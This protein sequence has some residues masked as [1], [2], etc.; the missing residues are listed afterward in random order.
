MDNQLLT[1]K[2]KDSAFLDYLPKIA[3]GAGIIFAG[4]IIGNGLLYLFN[5]IVAR[6]LGSAAYGLFSIGRIIINIAFMLALFGLQ[7]GILRYVSIY[8]GLRDNER[9]KGAIISALKVVIPLSLVVSALLFG[10]AETISTQIF[11]KKELTIVIKLFSISIPFISLSTIFISVTKGF[12]KMQ[13]TVYARHIFEPIIKMLLALTL[14]LI[15]WKLM[16]AV[17]AFVIANIFSLFLCFYYLKNLFPIFNSQIKPI[18]ETKKL[19]RF[20]FPLL[21]V[22]LLS[23]LMLRIDI[24]MLG[25]F[26]TAE[27][28]GIYSAAMQTS[29]LVLIILTSFNAIFAPII[30]DLY[31][32]KELSRL[33]SLFKTVTKWVFQLT[34]PIFLLMVIFARDILSLFGPTFM[35]GVIC[36]VILATAQ[37][38]NSC[39]GSV[40]Y[41]IMMSGRSNIN[42][43]NALFMCIMNIVLNYILIPAYGIIGAALATGISIV[44]INLIRLLEVYSLM[45]IHPYNSNFLKPFLAGIIS[46]LLLVIIRSTTSINQIF[47]L[48]LFSLT[49]LC[50]YA[51]LLYLFKFEQ[52]DR[53]IMIKIKEKLLSH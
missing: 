2:T 21:F 37:F 8:H 3:K 45:K 5:I 22:G 32:K 13:Y 18:Y 43:Y 31:N 36:L 38:I 1:E 23:L 51:F 53:F 24:L 4:T 17:L 9:L 16:G 30:A 6:F 7:S 28:V 12:Q 46:A 11:D 40:G 39:T 29:I 35:V 20:S 10:L 34:F 52:E 50:L 44:S 48:I 41:M 33:K 15:G 26:K 47:L 49:F 14:F 19:I 42:F 25:H 27:D